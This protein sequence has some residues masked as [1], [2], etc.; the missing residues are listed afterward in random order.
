VFCPRCRDEFRP[1]F[2]RCESCGVDLV[3]N[4]SDAPTRPARE[5][6][7][8]AAAA[9]PM[10]DY[11]GFF[12]LNDARSARER[13]AAEQILAD[14]VI[15]RSPEAARE[16]PL[17]EEYWLRVEAAK[18]R[19]A[20]PVLGFHDADSEQADEKLACSAC[21]EAVGAEATRC[22]RCGTIFEEP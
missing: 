12:D 7:R 6:D 1:G 17:G 4:L 20:A 3:E 11:C 5:S 16:N 2:T 15:R 14:I 22:A 18:Y 10:A 8:P 9:V 13:L 19:L 21:G